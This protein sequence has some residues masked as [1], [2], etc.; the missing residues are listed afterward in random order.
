MLVALQIGT[1]SIESSLAMSRKITHINTLV[2]ACIHIKHV[3]KDTQ[4]T[5]QMSYL[6]EG[7]LE[8]EEKGYEGNFF[9]V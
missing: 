5:D 4:E 6:C 7:H 3:Y 1:I 2:L 8:H 9:P